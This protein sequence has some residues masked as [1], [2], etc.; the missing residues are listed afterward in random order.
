MNA[1]TI[2]P[3][4]RSNARTAID[5]IASAR[6]VEIDKDNNA[7]L[8]EKNAAKTEIDN[9]VARAKADINSLNHNN[10]IEILKENKVNE[11]SQVVAHPV[12]KMLLHKQL[13]KPL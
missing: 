3:T 1:A 6:K 2:T 12:K 11:I 4:V 10:E 7:T 8:E 13:I 9:L 5:N